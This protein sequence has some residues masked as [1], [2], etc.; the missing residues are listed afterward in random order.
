FGLFYVL[1]TIISASG[2]PGISLLF[3]AVT[4]F[5][6]TILNFLLIPT[7]GLTGAAIATTVSMSLGATFG[8]IYLWSRFRTLF[9]SMTA[10]RLMA[11]A[12]VTYAVSLFLTPVSKL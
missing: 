6:S 7:R 4:L 11:C 8:C 3:G 9:S 2:R 12:G 10:M 1:T 5:V